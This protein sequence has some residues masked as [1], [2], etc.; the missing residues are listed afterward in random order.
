MPTHNL[1]QLFGTYLYRA[2]DSVQSRCD[3]RHIFHTSWTLILIDTSNEI[4]EEVDSLQLHLLF[5]Y[6]S[7]LKAQHPSDT[8]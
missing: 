6:S 1:L 8:T 2:K 3:N 4:G 7:I 5:S